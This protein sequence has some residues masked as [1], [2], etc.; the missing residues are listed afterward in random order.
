MKTVAEDETDGVANMTADMPLLLQICLPNAATDVPTLS[1]ADM[2]RVTDQLD[3]E[4]FLITSNKQKLFK[5]EFTICL[6]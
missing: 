6:I 2:E 1:M 5:M 4:I 3:R